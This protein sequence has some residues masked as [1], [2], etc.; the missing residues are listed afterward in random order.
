MKSDDVYNKRPP[1]KRPNPEFPDNWGPNRKPRISDEDILEALKRNNGTI[2]KTAADLGYSPV[3]IYRRID[4]DP[5]FFKGWKDLREEF[6]DKVEDEVGKIALAP[7]DDPNIRTSD[8]LKAAE[9]ILKN[10]RG[11]GDSKITL[12]GGFTHQVRFD[13]EAIK[14]LE[15]RLMKALGQSGEII[16]LE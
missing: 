14:Q 2:T 9:M 8:K 16:E 3:T 12:E 7:T 5:E 15:Q 13:L 4:A 1:E 11:F 6:L 10:R